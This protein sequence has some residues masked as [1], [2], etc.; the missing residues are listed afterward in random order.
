MQSFERPLLQIRII[1]NDCE[2]WAHLQNYMRWSSWKATLCISW[3]CL[4][5]KQ[6]KGKDPHVVGGE[7][8]RQPSMEW[9]RS[10][11]PPSLQQ[12][13]THRW[14]PSSASLSHRKGF[15]VPSDYLMTAT[16]K[17]SIVIIEQGDYV[18]V[19][20]NYFFS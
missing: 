11:R 10:P 6:H 3:A 8:L 18:G 4:S 20:F 16:R 19:L 12:V 17:A 15:H 5:E 7:G 14:A 1:L 13:S 2:N 9:G